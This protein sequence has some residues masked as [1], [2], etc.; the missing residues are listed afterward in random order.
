MPTQK[1]DLLKRL[2][3]SG[4]FQRALSSAR[5]DAEREGA[6]A[7]AEQLVREFAKVLAPLYDR[8]QDDPSLKEQLA[9]RLLE[10]RKVVTA[11]GPTSGSAG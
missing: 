10:D 9:R 4:T 1:P 3:E 6:R 7:A 5:S 2:R 11:A 8:L